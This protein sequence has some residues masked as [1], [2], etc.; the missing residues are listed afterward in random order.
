MPAVPPQ[1]IPAP[2]LVIRPQ[3]SLLAELVLAVPLPSW[4]T[5]QKKRQS[6][7]SPPNLEWGSPSCPDGA[8]SGLPPGQV[9]AVAQ[10]AAEW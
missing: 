4:Q 6:R 3:M 10:E 9:K 8:V 7:P 1:P 2:Y 5:S